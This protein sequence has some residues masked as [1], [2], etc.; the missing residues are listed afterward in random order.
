MDI[1]RYRGDT[2]SFSVLLEDENGALNLTS[3]TIKLTVNSKPTPTDTTNQLFQLTGTVSDPTSG[4]VSFSL[5]SPQADN[6]GY[7]YHDIQITD[8]TSAIITV[9]KGM[10]VMK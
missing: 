7:F 5:T 1:E 9:N 2:K 8:A 4:I 3:C 6:V 10:F